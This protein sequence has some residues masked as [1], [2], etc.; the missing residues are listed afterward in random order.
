MDSEEKVLIGKAELKAC[1]F[2]VASKAAIM[3]VFMDPKK[4]TA[5]SARKDIEDLVNELVEITFNRK[6]E[7]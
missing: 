3:T 2:L 7:E 1:L 5:E 4:D 6:R